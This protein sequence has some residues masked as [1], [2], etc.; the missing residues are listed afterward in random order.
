MTTTFNPIGGIQQSAAK[1]LIGLALSV[2]LLFSTAMSANAV[3]I[4]FF[5]EDNSAGGSLPAPNSAAAEAD[6]LSNLVGVT[7]ENF[8]S[9]TPGDIFPI[10]VT[11][12]L[13]TATLTGTNTITNTGIL[14]APVAGRF[15]ISGSQY[16]NVGTADAPSFTLSFS[17]PQAAF[18]FYGTD[19][20][21]FS[22]QLAIRL[23]G[24]TVISIAHT[25]PN[26]PNGSALFWGIID[27]DMPFSTVEF[28][29]VGG[30]D[31]DD[32]FGFD[33]FTIGRVD[34]VIPSSVPAP[35]TLALFALGLVGLGWSRRKECVNCPS[36][37]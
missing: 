33:D 30:G 25:N 16:L 8:E 31:F 5:G 2:G 23:D 26:G 37:V 7:T 29:N 21:D 27:T 12:G 18:G 4:I 6:F 24:G 28:V 3:P 19:I 36:G 17:S 10:D 34:Q 35:A 11:F 20:G 1:Y 22:G 14:N 9:L 32:A 13:D 15:A